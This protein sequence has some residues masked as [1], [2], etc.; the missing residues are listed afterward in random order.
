MNHTSVAIIVHN[1]NNNV[2]RNL[3]SAVSIESQ[4]PNLCKNY[5]IAYFDG[6]TNGS[7]I[8]YLQITAAI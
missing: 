7:L 3:R 5:M 2:S 4:S 1:M 6:F 8:I